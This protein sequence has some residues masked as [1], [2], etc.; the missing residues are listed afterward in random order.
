M[1]VQLS[2]SFTAIVTIVVPSYNHAFF[3]IEAL[4][5]VRQQTMPH[6]EMLVIDDGSTDETW[7]V[8]MAFKETV[9]D[10]RIS[11]IQQPNAGSHATLNRGLN[12]AKTPYLA[13]LNSD[14]AYEPKRLERLL[15]IAS[16]AGKYFFAT[17]G[18]TLIDRL[19]DPAPVTHPWL[20]M[21]KGIINKWN[22]HKLKKISNPAVNTLLDGN[23]T[24]ST[25][26]FF[27]SR[28]IWLHVGEFRHLKYIPDWDYA[29]RVGAQFPD[30]FFFIPNESLLRY[31]LHGANTILSGAL[32]IHMETVY[33]LRKF[34]KQWIKDGN[35]FPLHAINKLH[36]LY[37][38][39][40]HHYT[41]QT[42]KNQE[43]FWN[44]LL[45]DVSKKLRQSQIES[46]ELKQ[47]MLHSRAEFFELQRQMTE[48]YASRSWQLTA[49]LR[50]ARRMITAK[51]DTAISLG[52]KASQS[53][54]NAFLNAGQ[55]LWRRLPIP[56]SQKR[57]IKHRIFSLL[58]N[59]FI[60]FTPF[61]NWKALTAQQEGMFQSSDDVNL[62][63]DLNLNLNLNSSLNSYIP[64][65]QNANPT[66]N[67]I[68]VRLIAFYLPQF[69][70]IPENNRWWGDGFTEWT[71]VRPAKPQFES[72][73]QPRIPGELGYY[74]LLDD[75]VQLRQVELAKLYGI[76]AFC[77][78][79]YW[80]AGKLL[81][82]KPIENY[83]KNQ[84]LDLPFCLCWAN[85]NWSRRWDGLDSHTLI[86]Q[87]HSPEDDINFIKYLKKYFDD[88]RYV[89]VN[90]K[91][92]LLVYR[93]TLLPDAK[94]TAGRWRQWCRMNG[95]GEIFLAYTQSFDMANPKDYGFDAA[96]E[97]PP[98]NASLP[99]IT[100]KVKPLNSDFDSSVY[101]WSV[102][103]KRSRNYS[104]TNYMLFR[105]VNP[106]WDNTA[107]RKNKGSVLLNSS[108]CGYQD[109]L[110]NAIKE[111]CSNFAKNQERIIFINAWNEWAEGA[112]LEPDERYGYAYL[113]ATRL[114]L[115][116][117][118]LT[119][120]SHQSINKNVIPIVIHVFYVDVFNHILEYL[121]K[122]N[123]FV[124]KLYITTS[125]ENQNSVRTILEAHPFDF[126]LH[127]TENRGRDILPF[128]KIMPFVISDG[129]E[130][131]LKIHTKKSLH[132][133]DGNEW[134]DDIYRKL[135]ATASIIEAV[136]LFQK[137]PHV[138]IIGPDGHMVAMSYYWG[139]NAK[140]VICLARRLGIEA[141]ALSNMNFIAGS[142]F[143][144]RTDAMLPILNLAIEDTDFESESGQI[145]GTLAH[146]I[147]RLFA[148]SAH[149]IQMT[150]VCPS[151]VRLIEYEFAKR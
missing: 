65:L 86:E 118:S 31:R 127:T 145:D 64:I 129:H 140:N 20:I 142:M 23:F 37:R 130:F 19:G 146:A 40:R 12:M 144:S 123:D 32:K 58:P 117:S 57:Y 69:H 88:T 39:I 150:T 42:L 62:D 55:L 95:V 102:L 3:I 98:I 41:R 75:A 96:I 103:A 97:F 59:F 21:Y 77:F 45:S 78:Y 17:T 66:P 74:D 76:G 36:H 25:S 121:K 149:S 148:V 49:H 124:L 7:A 43:I 15:D 147:E 101:D 67:S 33:V 132:R 131:F 46:T 16:S 91:P 114:A 1:S 134:R 44:E 125:L 92:L 8:L 63:L 128:L 100:E 53:K 79:T 115:L 56:E 120:K 73:Y 104:K 94:Q 106:S 111:T 85:E 9:K 136:R 4:D 81:L 18:V 119:I 151:N 122:I 93:P 11:F 107:R 2:P 5:S 38:S 137:N 28:S 109:W 47:Q 13:I 10:P 83:L 48:I 138:G 135:M 99:N 89:R 143:F 72:H 51:Y 54:H 52:R 113:E 68:P 84:S 90:D 139:S 116:R 87:Q 126:Y 133:T 61:E 30:S 71:N 50:N 35:V 34:Q 6:W 112:Y 80:F 108:P 27:M 70:A 82:E 22:G 14:D 60:R 29:L 110:V 141:N 105:G 24:V 26:N